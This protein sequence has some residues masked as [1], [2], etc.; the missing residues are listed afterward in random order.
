MGLIS[1][2]LWLQMKR[3]GV[4]LGEK[5]LPSM[6]KALDL[7]PKQT[8]QDNNNT[9]NAGDANLSSYLIGCIDG[10][11]EEQALGRW[12]GLSLCL[13]VALQGSLCKP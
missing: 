8:K 10:S 3:V 12:F 7:D 1:M 9:K 5:R 2:D 4:Q 13:G 6:L 11:G